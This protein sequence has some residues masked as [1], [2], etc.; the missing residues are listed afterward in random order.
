MDVKVRGTNMVVTPGIEEFA[1]SKIT[2]LS[3]Y[4]PNISHLHVDFTEQKNSRG[5]NYIACQITLRHARG[6]ILRSEERVETGDGNAARAALTGAV[7]KMYSRIQ[8]FKGK[9]RSRRMR[10]RYRATME[11]LALA[12]EL[13]EDSEW[14]ESG[15]YDESET[16]RIIRRKNVSVTAMNEEEA[17]EQMELLGHT[18][19]MFF[20]MDNNQINVVYKRRV[21]GYGLLIPQIE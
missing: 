11:E 9:R 12:E 15:D 8:R 13:P 21:G 1:Q 10:D 5:R 20:N 3:R 16:D 19:F 2:K 17:I 14:D 6:A 18:F 7:D 4:L